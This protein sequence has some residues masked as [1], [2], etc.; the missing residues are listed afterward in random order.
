MIYCIS[1]LLIFLFIL[2]FHYIRIIDIAKNAIMTSS[3]STKVLRDTNL[4]DI[5]KEKLIRYHSLQLLFS[6]VSILFRF[7][8]LFFFLTSALFAFQFIGLINA[9]EVVQFLSSWE[10][11]LVT[12]IFM[13]ILFVWVYK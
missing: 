10:V 6:F 3:E 13:T 5:Q 8:I 2:G 11:I 9:S 7:F 1:V 4:D 12:T